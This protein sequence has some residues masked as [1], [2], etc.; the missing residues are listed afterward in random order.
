METGRIVCLNSTLA[1]E[2]PK[3][4]GNTSAEAQIG[5]YAIVV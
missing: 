2:R 4:G 3:L 5:F 1:L